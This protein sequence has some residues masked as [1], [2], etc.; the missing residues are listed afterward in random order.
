MECLAVGCPLTAAGAEGFLLGAPRGAFAELALGLHVTVFPRWPPYPPLAARKL[1]SAPGGPRGG[2]SGRGWRHLS[3]SANCP[4][5]M[6][7]SQRTTDPGH[8]APVLGDRVS[9]HQG[10]EQ[11]EGKWGMEEQVWGAGRVP[12]AWVTELHVGIVLYVQWEEPCG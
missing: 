6:L 7:S 4:Q 5:S 10:Q 11:D 1:T 3:L 8:G 9:H 12:R 2:M